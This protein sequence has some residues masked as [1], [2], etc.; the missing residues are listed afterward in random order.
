[1]SD[2]LRPVTRPRMYEQV[3]AQLREH[4]AS[5]GLQ[6]GDRLPPERELADRLQVSRASIKQAVVVLEVQGLVESRHGGGVY[7]RTSSLD[8]EP[9]AAL[10]DRRRRLPDVLDAREAIETKLAELAALRRTDDDL[11]AIEAALEVMRTQ[12][13][14]GELGEDGDRQFHAAVAAAARSTLLTDFMQGIREGIAESRHESL[15][16]LDRPPK[17]LAQHR[18]IAEAIRAQDAA[19]AAAAMKEHLETVS[20]VRLL[21]WNPEA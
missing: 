12:I 14:D 2:S 7:L 3:M 10:V 9:L 11:T 5:E 21:T 18:R 1:M 8:P 6:A 19:A 13:D 4:V 20:R 16:Q 17:S 15:Q